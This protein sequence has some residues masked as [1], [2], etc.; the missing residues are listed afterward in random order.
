MI[1]LVLCADA[2][3]ITLVFTRVIDMANF[4]ITQEWRLILG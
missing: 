4:K 1:Q 2:L 3:G